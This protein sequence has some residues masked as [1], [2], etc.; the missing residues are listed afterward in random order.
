[1]TSIRREKKSKT[2]VRDVSVLFFLKQFNSNQPIISLFLYSCA[3]AERLR[4]R[5]INIS[6]I[7]VFRHSNVVCVPGYV[8]S[9]KKE[10]R[11]TI[12]LAVFWL[13]RG[14]KNPP[15]WRTTKLDSLASRFSFIKS[16]MHRVA[17]AAV[18]MIRR[19]WIFFLFS[20]LFPRRIHFLK[21]KKFKRLVN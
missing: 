13:A 16:R 20:I 15:K 18:D 12:I 3:Y 14:V 21:F 4:H 7:T 5:W 10:K 8:H 9:C 17:A 1:M 6:V 2:D 19:E 11:I